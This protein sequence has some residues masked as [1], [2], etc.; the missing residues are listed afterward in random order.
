MV[1]NEEV[2]DTEIKLRSFVQNFT[3]LEDVIKQKTTV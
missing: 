2:I 3:L 1:G